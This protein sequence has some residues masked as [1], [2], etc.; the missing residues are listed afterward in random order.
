MGSVKMAEDVVDVR[1]KAIMPE[2]K[3][4]LSDADRRIGA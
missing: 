1:D 3:V 4:F 2:I